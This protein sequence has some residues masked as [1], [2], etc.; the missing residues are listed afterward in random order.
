MC[1]L[2]LNILKNENK[3]S[4]RL[5]VIS[6]CNNKYH[7]KGFCEYHYVR[8]SFGRIAQKK[9]RQSEKSKILKNK[10]I[11]SGIIQK[12]AKKYRDSSKGRLTMKKLH[13]K[14]FNL[15]LEEY[16]IMKEE[17]KNKCA[18]CKKNET[19]FTKNN[20]R[21]ELAIDHDHKTSK[22]RG[23]LCKDCNVKLSIKEN[24]KWND[25]AGQYLK[26]YYQNNS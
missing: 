13:L 19:T 5:C 3:Q 16:Y 11:K 9:F 1:S 26:K 21:R 22:T 14:Q 2:T 4:I 20:K 8:S 25:L 10:Y 6:N 18:I 7:A 23:L 24:K 15:T 17:Q 12:S